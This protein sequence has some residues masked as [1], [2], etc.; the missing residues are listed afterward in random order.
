MRML[1]AAA[2]PTLDSDFRELLAI[3]FPHI[4][5]VRFIMKQT[6]PV[7]LDF[8][9]MIEEFQVTSFFTTVF[10]LLMAIARLGRSF[11]RTLSAQELA[12][13]S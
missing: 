13:I 5:D 8:S 7:H 1:T 12:P 10:H 11:L 2:L 6:R 4:Y 3:W 9:E